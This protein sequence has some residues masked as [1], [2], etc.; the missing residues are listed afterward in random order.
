[1]I[2]NSIE[3]AGAVFAHS[4]ALI[5][6]C[7]RE[8]PRILFNLIVRFTAHN[9]RRV[10]RAQ[11]VL[12]KRSNSARKSIIGLFSLALLLVMLGNVVQ[13]QVTGPPPATAAAVAVAPGMRHV[14]ILPRSDLTQLQ[15]FPNPATGERIVVYT[16]GV[17]ILIDGL[18][19]RAGQFTFS[20]SIDITAD[21]VVAW[22]NDNQLETGQATQ[23][24]NAPLELYMEGNVVFREGDRIIQAKAFYYNVPSITA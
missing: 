2:A 5:D 15:S 11:F 18:P 3:V 21:R 12:R 8:F 10:G 24:E 1:M 23:S 22:T 9:V 16:G 19:S 7:V 6:L 4:P 13:A 14:Q 20:G 17:T